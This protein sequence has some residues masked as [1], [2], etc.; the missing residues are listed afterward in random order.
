MRRVVVQQHWVHPEYRIAPAEKRPTRKPLDAV[1]VF[2]FLSSITLLFVVTVLVY[3]LQRASVPEV[4]SSAISAFSS[5]GEFRGKEDVIK[6]LSAEQRKVFASQVHYVLEII[7]STKRKKSEKDASELAQLIVA[8][9][10]RANYDP[11]FV[12]SVIKAEST[13]N[14]RAVSYA[15]AKGLMQILPG[16]GQYVSKR[17]RL[18]WKG[19]QTLHN[20][21]YNLQL[22]IAYLKELEKNFKGDRELALIAYN[23]GPANV[24]SAAQGKKR[25]PSSSVRYAKGII[26][27]HDKWRREL[28]SRRNQFQYLNLDISA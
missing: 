23:W 11:L 18:A 27:S 21:E 6:S 9:S 12:A 13:F 8:E 7:R 17:N 16:T 5:I 19:S 26:S 10:Y 15:G 2:L 1:T 22:G 4:I 14:H 24:M 3:P 25:F 20:P 28:D